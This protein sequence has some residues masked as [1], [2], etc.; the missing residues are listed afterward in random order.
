MFFPE[1]RGVILGLSLL[2]SYHLL[3]STHVLLNRKV[4][5]LRLIPLPTLKIIQLKN[6]K[7]SLV[8]SAVLVVSLTVVYSK[9]CVQYDNV[10]VSSTQTGRSCRISLSRPHSYSS[11]DSTELPDLDTLAV[12]YIEAGR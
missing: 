11:V 4:S 8:I 10:Q 1:S 12:L 6:S 7:K 2:F 5:S 3:L 9:I